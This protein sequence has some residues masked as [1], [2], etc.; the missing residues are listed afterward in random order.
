MIK[1]F[2][3]GLSLTVLTIIALQALIDICELRLPENIKI[4]SVF[5]PFAIGVG[6]TIIYAVTNGFTDVE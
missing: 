3:I 5:I 4:G 2:L 6:F 1:M